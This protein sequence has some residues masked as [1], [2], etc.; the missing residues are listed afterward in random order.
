M[1]L[2]DK[3]SN[4]RA[5]AKSPPHW[6]PLERRRAC[7]NWAGDVADGLRGVSD[8][9]DAEFDEARQLAEAKVAEAEAKAS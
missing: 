2:A 7:V 1:K 4:L 5:I 6:W 8:W 3:T 9:L